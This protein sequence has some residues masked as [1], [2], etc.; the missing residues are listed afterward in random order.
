MHTLNSP[1]HDAVGADSK[2]SWTGPILPY[3]ASASPQTKRSPE[4]PRLTAIT[5]VLSDAIQHERTLPTALRSDLS[6]AD[7]T[8]M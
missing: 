3:I 4:P 1:T 2:N 5:G 8:L 6:L 7:G